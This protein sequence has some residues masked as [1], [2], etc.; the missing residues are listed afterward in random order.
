MSFT[1]TIRARN[2]NIIEID[3]FLINLELLQEHASLAFIFP[4]V[5]AHKLCLL[6]RTV[7]PCGE[8]ERV[9]MKCQDVLIVLIRD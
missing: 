2:R 7:L 9:I 8:F 4:K 6:Q 1:G 3:T 5:F